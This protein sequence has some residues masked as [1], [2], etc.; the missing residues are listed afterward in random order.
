MNVSRLF[1]GVS[2]VRNSSVGDICGSDAGADARV[3]KDGLPKVVVEC[4]GIRAPAR[5]ATALG[6]IDL[7]RRDPPRGISEVSIA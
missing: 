3:L 2:K 4:A 6:S 5:F 7:R 1:F